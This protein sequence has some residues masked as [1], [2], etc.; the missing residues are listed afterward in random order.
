MLLFHGNLD[1]NVGIGESELMENRL[2]A[3]GKQVRLVKFDGLAH[4]LDDSAAR[5]E[6]LETSDAFLR[7]T[8][9]L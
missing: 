7:K 5:A 6:M 9:G 8:L 2:Q 1:Q 4:Q 3:A